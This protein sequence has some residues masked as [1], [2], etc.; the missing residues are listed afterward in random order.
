M[1]AVRFQRRG[2]TT[3][4]TFA[5]NP[6]IVELLKASVPSFLRSWNPD[7]R[8]WLILEPV[9][10]T[11]FAD[12][13]RR[14]GHNIVGLDDPPAQ[15]YHG[16]D[17]ADWAHLLFKRVGRQRCDQVYRALSRCLHP[18]VGGDTDLQRE[19]NDAYAIVGFLWEKSHPVFEQVRE[20]YR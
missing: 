12:T 3:A 4:V 9:Y 16:T 1:T 10:A 8:E 18:D 19:L 15:R 5:Y 7:R 2:D 13:L 20:G 14:L 6:D 11:Q 17:S